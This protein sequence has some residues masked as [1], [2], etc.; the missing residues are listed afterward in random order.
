MITLTTT[1][2]EGRCKEF[3]KLFCELLNGQLGNKYAPNN[4]Y[5][6]KNI[7][8]TTVYT[9]TQK[10]Y[11]EGSA[12]KLKRKTGEET[13]SPDTVFRWLQALTLDQILTMFDAFVVHTLFRARKKGVLDGP[14]LIALDC[15]DVP[16]YGKE[17]P[18]A[19][20]GT[21]EKR[22]TNYAFQ[23]LVADIVVAGE[24]FTLAILPVPALAHLPSL[25]KK[26]LEKVKTHVEVEA[27]MVDK[28]FFGTE[29]I[30]E[31]IAQGIIYEMP[32]PRNDL[33]KEHI[34]ASQ[35]FRYNI[36]DYQINSTNGKKS[37]VTTLVIA[38][39]PRKKREI[40]ERDK[41]FVFLTNGHVD[42]D[43]IRYYISRYDR[44]WGIET[45]FRVRNEFWIKTN[46][47]KVVLR[48]LFFFLAAMMYDFWLLA[49][50]LSDWKPN[51][52]YDYEILAREF[53]DG[54]EDLI[55]A[56]EQDPG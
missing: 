43:R 47:D 3:V 21:K 2:I 53:R 1:F 19:V 32:A 36:L 26:I 18:P 10:S 29:T 40:V 17:K 20:R 23:Y 35:G 37:V 51:P 49:N 39:S 56:M 13:P 41:E 5:S 31:F 14:V 38:P 9:A 46:T 15:T 4:V 7:V 34:K 25:V 28:G 48:Y 45:G 16:Y 30:L 22:G 50:I 55:L 54:L 44:R 27:V 52:H 12:T 42:E 24:R 8:K 33:V 11:T 6:L